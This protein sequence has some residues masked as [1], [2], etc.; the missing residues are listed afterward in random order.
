MVAGF[1]GAFD[2]G[3]GGF[4]AGDEIKL[5]PG[6]AGGC[7]FDVFELVTGNGGEDIGGARFAGGAGGGDVAAGMHKAAVA[8]GGE[9]GGERDFLAG[10]LRGEIALARGDGMTRAERE[11]FKGTDVFAE[12]EFALGAAFDVIEDYAGET[13]LGQS[14]QVVNADGTRGG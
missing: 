13:L 2:S 9:D 4:A 8:D 1:A 14:S 7:G 6:G 12:S 10:N 5:I 11:G 3:F